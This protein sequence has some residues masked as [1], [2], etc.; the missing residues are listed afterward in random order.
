[1]SEL[2]RRARRP[3]RYRLPRTNHITFPRELRHAIP[4]LPTCQGRVLQLDAVTAAMSSSFLGT[5]VN[6][7][8]LACETGK[9]KG[10]YTVSMDLQPEAARRLAE[11][12]NQMADQADPTH[13]RM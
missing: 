8:L 11:L 4:D 13:S 5:R 6:L 9:L 3:A 1:M 7:K 10:K 2:V 12:L